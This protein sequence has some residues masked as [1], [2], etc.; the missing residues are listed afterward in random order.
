LRANAYGPV[1]SCGLYLT[2]AKE[3]ADELESYS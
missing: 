1:A 3:R 2:K